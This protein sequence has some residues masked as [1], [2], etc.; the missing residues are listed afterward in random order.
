MKTLKSVYLYVSDNQTEVLIS[1]SGLVHDPLGFSA[2][3]GEWIKFQHDDFFRQCSIVLGILLD[4]EPLWHD[5]NGDS[6]KSADANEKNMSR[7]AKK[8]LKKFKMLF[9]TTGGYGP[10]GITVT[11]AKII[12][13]IRFSFTETEP[14]SEVAE[15]FRTALV[16]SGWWEK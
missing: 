13:E 2:P 8:Y 11:G 7:A 1:R 15:K 12:D 5:N 14:P 16:K 3:I 4:E 9:V 10:P 6:M